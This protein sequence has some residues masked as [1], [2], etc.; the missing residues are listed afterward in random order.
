[1][2]LQPLGPAQTAWSSR[3][4]GTGRPERT[5]PFRFSARSGLSLK[6]TFSEHRKMVRGPRKGG[7]NGDQ[8]DV[9]KEKDIG[10]KMLLFD[11]IC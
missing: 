7:G 4:R 3:R 8:G 6:F 1:M 10:I 2:S 5:D 11:I 9:V